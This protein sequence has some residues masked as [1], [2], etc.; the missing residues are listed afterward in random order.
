MKSTRKRPWL[1]FSVR[2]LLVGIAVVASILAWK[3]EQSRRIEQAL[4]R[5]RELGGY[6]ALRSEPSPW[7][8]RLAMPH[9]EVVSLDETLATN[10]DVRHLEMLHSLTRLKLSQTELSPGGLAPLASLQNLTLL[11]LGK[12]AVNDFD[13]QHIAGLT[14]LATLELHDTAITDGGLIHLRR[15]ASLDRLSLQGTSVTSSGLQ[16]LAPLIRLRALSLDENQASAP[17]AE[18][19]GRL[20]SLAEIHVYVHSG[21][22]RGAWELYRA[23]PTLN[24]TAII[25]GTEQRLWHSSIPWESST[26][27]ICEQISNEAYFSSDEQQKLLQVLVR[28]RAHGNWLNAPRPSQPRPNVAEIPEEDRIRSLEAFLEAIAGPISG[29]YWERYTHAEQYALSVPPEEIIPVL[30]TIIKEQPT[31]VDPQDRRPSAIRLLA[32][33]GRGND[34]ALEVLADA[35]RDPELGSAT[36]WVFMTAVAREQEL[37]ALKVLIDVA[38][39]NDWQVRSGAAAGMRQIIESRPELTDEVFAVL[40]NMLEKDRHTGSLEYIVRAL[41]ACGRHSP[42]SLNS[43]IESFANLARGP[44]HLNEYPR[45]ALSSFLAIKAAN[46]PSF[47]RE[48]MEMAEDAHPVIAKAAGDALISFATRLAESA[49]DAPTDK[50]TNL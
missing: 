42:K 31:S 8:R 4:R 11:T 24:I 13:L 14:K 37:M 40:V 18:H 26:A 25:A 20:E 7:L 9:A 17:A 12:T 41:E 49:A 34:E 28:A 5:I 46:D 36:A 16:H 47:V 3:L 48:L 1:R 27:G 21:V 29:Q 22:G 50:S 2:S 32:R 15:L 23:L 33:V 43:G 39:D 6:V 30:I 35:F 10:E 38:D 45:Q 19:L 44:V